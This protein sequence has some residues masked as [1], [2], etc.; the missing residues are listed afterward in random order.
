MI[1]F[2]ITFVT[3]QRNTESLVLYGYW[4]KLTVEHSAADIVLA[5]MRVLLTALQLL[6]YIMSPEVAGSVGCHSLLI[7]ES[8]VATRNTTA[9]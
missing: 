7:A 8:Q 5:L 9:L 4:S 6:L 3:C 1:S 2:V